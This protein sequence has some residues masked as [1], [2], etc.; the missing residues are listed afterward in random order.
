M[1][2]DGSR[3]QAPEAAGRPGRIATAMGCFGAADDSG[4]ARRG[5]ERPGPSGD[6]DM[7]F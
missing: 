5:A 4:H 6:D 7:G 1:P 3:G 2:P